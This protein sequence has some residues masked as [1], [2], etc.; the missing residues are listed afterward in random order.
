MIIMPNKISNNNNVNRKHS[1]NNT[2]ITT[3]NGAE[4]EER[5]NRSKYISQSSHAKPNKLHI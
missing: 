4:R 1:H 5:A 3:D 2:R